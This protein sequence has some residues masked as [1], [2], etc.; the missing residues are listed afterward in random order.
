MVIAAQHEMLMNCSISVGN[1]ISVLV[2]R[3]WM[4][5]LVRFLEMV[6]RSCSA[7]NSMSNQDHQMMR[8]LT[9]AHSRVYGLMRLTLSS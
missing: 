1:M 4:G 7:F 9:E 8:T 5:P 6:P 3:I 2:I